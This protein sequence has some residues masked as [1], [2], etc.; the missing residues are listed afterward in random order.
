MLIWLAILGTAQ[1][2]IEKRRRKIL[3]ILPSNPLEGKTYKEIADEVDSSES[4]VRSDLIA[5]QGEKLV[6]RD[7]RRPYTWYK[8]SAK[9][10]SV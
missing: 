7:D 8:I 3:S 2:R 10:V 9:K 6:N 1:K 4:S 5:L